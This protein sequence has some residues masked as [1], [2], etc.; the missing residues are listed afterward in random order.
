MKN[1]KEVTEFVEKHLNVDLTSKL[2]KKKRTDDLV[3][4]RCVVYHICRSNF[5]MSL[6][7]IG[8][9]FDK[10]HSTVLHSLRTSL[11][12]IL[13]EKVYSDVIKRANAIIEMAR[14]SEKDTVKE[15][16]NLEDL[17]YDYNKLKSENRQL[18]KELSSLEE[19]TKELRRYID[20]MPM[21][22]ELSMYFSRMDS[23]KRAL[24]EERVLNAA[25]MIYN[26]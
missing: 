16:L 12:F 15:Y 3:L 19:Q 17:Q 18:K 10:D 4:A 8:A 7:K 6:A 13:S 26:A 20:S 24:A 1:I 9:N 23:S 14:G 11:D 25:R 21:H 22:K 2:N 5:G